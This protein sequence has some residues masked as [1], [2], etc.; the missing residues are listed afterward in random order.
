[1]HPIKLLVFVGAPG[2]RADFIAGWV[3]KLPNFVE[4]SW[5]FNPVTRQSITSTQHTLCLDYPE[6][7]TSFLN[8]H[9]YVLDAN[10]PLTYA[11]KV[12][13]VSNECS[14][15]I[16]SKTVNLIPINLEGVDSNIIHWESLIKTLGRAHRLH[17]A[18]WVIDQ[19]IDKD[20]IS[21][22]DRISYL[23]QHLKTRFQEKRQLPIY[24]NGLKYIEIFKKGGSYLIAD[25]IGVSASKEYHQYWD[26]MLPMAE[27][28]H[29]VILWGHEF[30]LSEYISC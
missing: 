11:T 10:S 9:Q 29:S 7:L 17:T 13:Q 14:Q 25:A 21:D 5:S 28:P 15:I 18:S 22:E 30:K 4:S 27:T 16:D 8:D 24:N 2:A 12:H 23:D 19:W 20:H 1:M 6:Q 3:G 26:Y